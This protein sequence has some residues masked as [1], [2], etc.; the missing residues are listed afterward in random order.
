MRQGR[1][2]MFDLSICLTDGPLL[3]LFIDS[4]YR[5]LM[6]AISLISVAR[7]IMCTCRISTVLPSFLNEMRN[8]PQDWTSLRAAVRN[9]KERKLSMF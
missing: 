5:D 9:Q 6:E 1:V 4:G 3:L 2:S 7:R 8:C